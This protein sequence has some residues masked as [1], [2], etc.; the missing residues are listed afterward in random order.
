MT[1]RRSAAWLLLL[2]I[3]CG[4]SA[5]SRPAESASAEGDEAATDGPTTAEGSEDDGEEAEPAPRRVNCDDG[6]CF[7]CGESLC[8]T[9]WYCDQSAKGGPACGWLPDCAAKTSCGCVSRVFSSCSCEE[10]SGGVHLTCG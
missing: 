6:T 9:G 3:S 10:K 7:A 5:G 1:A 8:P 4:G 2:A